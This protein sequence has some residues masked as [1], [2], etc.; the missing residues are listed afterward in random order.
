M[1]KNGASPS[2]AKKRK[3]KESQTEQSQRFVET[4]KAL[5]CDETGEAFEKAIGATIKARKSPI[6]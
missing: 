1:K 4:A 3:S 2:I 6:K 5:E